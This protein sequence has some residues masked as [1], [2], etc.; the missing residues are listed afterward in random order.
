MS[1]MQLAA[2][3]Q[4]KSAKGSG[5][6]KA[7]NTLRDWIV[8][9]EMP[10][11][12]DIDEQAL[13]EE[14]GISRTPL[15]EAM[16]RLAAEGLISLLPNRGARVASMGI[17]QLQ[18][19]LEA[20]ELAQRAATRLAAVRRTNA[21]IERIEQ[22]VLAFEDAH[23]NGDVSGMIDRNWELHIAIGNACGNRVLAKIYTNLLT[24]NIR[25]ARIAMSYESFPSAEARH[26]HLENILREHREMLDAIKQQDADRAEELAHSHTGLARK[27]VTEYISHSA[28]SDVSISPRTINPLVKELSNV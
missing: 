9:L 28:V 13:G 23:A 8:S 26:S 19:H 22:L 3:G 20:L 27:R 11:G 15:R 24:E 2:A 14:L 17:S 18:E 4:K 6:N 10:P 21:D 16:I 12:E 5:A 1:K 25:V 7:Y